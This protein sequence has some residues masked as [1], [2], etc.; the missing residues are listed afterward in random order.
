MISADKAK[1]VRALLP[2]HVV[3]D[4]NVILLEV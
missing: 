2:S 1:A 3:C 4:K